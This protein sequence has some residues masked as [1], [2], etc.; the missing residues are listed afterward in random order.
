MLTVEILQLPELRS[1]LSGEYPTTELSQFRSAGLGSLIY[2]LEAD[3]TE[4]T[5]FNSFYTV[6][7]GGCLAIARI[8]L[9]C[10]PAVTKQRMFLLT[11][12]A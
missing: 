7:M 8:M 1:F 5:A 11:T 3:I 10:L 12:V 9:T 2:S 4:N 6:V